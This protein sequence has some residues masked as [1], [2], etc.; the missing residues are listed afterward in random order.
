MKKISNEARKYRCKC[1]SRLGHLSPFQIRPTTSTRK[2]TDICPST[3]GVKPSRL[4][5]CELLL[6]AVQCP[7]ALPARPA[8]AKDNTIAQRQ[9]SA[10]PGWEGRSSLQSEDQRTGRRGLED[11]PT[12]GRDCRHGAGVIFLC[13]VSEVIRYYITSRECIDWR[14]DV[15]AWFS[16]PVI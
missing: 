2:K 16:Q 9:P 3:T 13:C 11:R 7:P 4:P 15:A 10:Q 14:C 8:A 5:S 12:R 6:R 1:E